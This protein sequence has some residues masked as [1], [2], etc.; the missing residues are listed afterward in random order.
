M[1]ADGMLDEEEKQDLEIA[2]LG[3]R[4]LPT[5]AALKGS[6]SKKEIQMSKQSTRKVR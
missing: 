2:K 5:V 3:P 1:D 6:G 4:R